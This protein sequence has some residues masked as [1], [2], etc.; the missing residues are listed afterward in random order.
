MFALRISAN[1]CRSPYRFWLLAVFC[2]I[3][4]VSAQYSFDVWTAHTGPQNV[5]SGISQTADGYLWLATCDGLIRFDGVRFTVFNKSN[6]PGIDSNQFESLYQ[7]R[8]GDLWLTTESNGITRYRR[9]SFTTYTTQ[10][11]LP[12][13][14][15]RGI[16]GD[17]A[18]NLWVL[19]GNSIARWQEAAERF[20]DVTPEG[21]NIAYSSLLWQPQDGFWGTDDAGLHCFLKGD[22]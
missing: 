12:Y 14:S 5:I 17:T 11:G 22:L 13:N 18:G 3:S 7:D 16:T 6:S 1:A 4:P 15:V 10:H 8:N 9:G 2:A 21:L 20:I 19:S